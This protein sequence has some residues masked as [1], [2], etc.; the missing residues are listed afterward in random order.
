MSMIYLDHNATTPVL[1]EVAEAMQPWLVEHYGNPSSVHRAGRLA[2]Q[3]LDQA[4]AEVAALVGCQPGEVVFT[5][6][7]T[8]A[9]NLA[10]QAVQGKGARIL[11]G[12]TEHAAVLEAAGARARSGVTVEHLAVDRQGRIDIAELEQGLARNAGPCLV[13]IMW[14]NNESGVVQDMA[15]LGLCAQEHGA[16]MHSDAVQA[17]GKLALDFSSAPVDLLSLSA[18]K[19]NGPKGVGALIVRSSASLHPLLHGGGHERGRRAGTENLP[20]IVG[21]GVAARLAH[22]ELEQRSSKAGRLRDQLEQKLQALPQVEIIGRAAPRVANTC[23]FTVSGFHSEALLMEL[24]RRGI[25]VA[26]GSACHAGTGR[27]SHVLLAMGYGEE[28]AHG[29][30]RV[31][32]GAGN[33]DADVE[34]FYTALQDILARPSLPSGLLVN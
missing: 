12:A 24:D 17:A 14:A 3:A 19:I 28:Q 7:G 27:P 16:L 20:G 21:F 8:E 10:V 32:L 11:C 30:I 5:S 15:A 6:G 4:R 13:S 26:S 2:R 1:P 22:A 25:A 18:H 34:R 9:D 23:Q 31:S 29:A 33:T